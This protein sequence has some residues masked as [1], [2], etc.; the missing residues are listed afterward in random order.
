MIAAL[1]L[2]LVLSADPGA[3]PPVIAPSGLPGVT[4]PAA[5]GPA[6]PND[7]LVRVPGCALRLGWS[8][9]RSSTLGSFRR[10]GSA[11]GGEV[12]EGEIRWFGSPARASL[13]YRSGRIADA[14]L[15]S[16]P[17]SPR[18]AG[19]VPDELRRRG[20]R[21]VGEV[22]T[23]GTSVSEWE[24]G[25]KIRLTIGGGSVT[26]EVSPRS[27][28]A[29]EEP[30]ADSG[31][32]GR[33]LPSATPVSEGTPPLDFTTDG[34]A[35]SLPAPRRTVTPAAP[36]RPRMAV[37][38]GVFG[39]VM[40]RARVD[41]EGKVEQVEIERGIAELNHEALEWAGAVRFA[42][43]LHQGRAVPFVVRIPVAFLPARAAGSPATP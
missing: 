39:R 2:G 35:A 36:V 1:V 19:Y 42:P 33:E 7:T 14:R 23:S 21:R 41:A 5:P 27:M 29:F 37:D 31:A 15:V 22:L 12:H 34:A 26:A 40:V 43:Y 4:P 32:P 38:A 30:A 8:Q 28:P 16:S 3:A 10:V 17:A 9:E 20:Y 18:L 25:S 11:A 6:A 13:T 24:G